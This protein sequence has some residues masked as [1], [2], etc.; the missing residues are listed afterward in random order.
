MLSLRALKTSLTSS[1][2]AALSIF[3]LYAWPAIFLSAIASLAIVHVLIC[4]NSFFMNLFSVNWVSSK[5][6]VSRE[7]ELI[8]GVT[9]GFNRPFSQHLH[10]NL[11]PLLIEELCSLWPYRCNFR[12]I[13]K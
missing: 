3:R 2:N 4:R 9:L 12:A 1:N 13:S 6:L 5:D 7:H 10:S 8:S 11:T